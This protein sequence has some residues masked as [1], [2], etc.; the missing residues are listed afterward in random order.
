MPKKA[1]SGDESPW[2]S[3][4]YCFLLGVVEQVTET[5]AEVT[6]RIVRVTEGRSKI[7]KERSK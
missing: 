6:D 4:F 3:L 7:R 1:M 5:R 2:H